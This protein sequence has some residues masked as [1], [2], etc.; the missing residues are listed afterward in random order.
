M[1]KAALISPY[2]DTLGGGEKYFLDI[3]LALEKLGIKTTLFW[4]NNI[5]EKIVEQYGV[6]YRIIELSTK[7]D[8]MSP[9][10]KLLFTRQFDYLFFITDGSYFFSLAKK[11]FVLLQVPQNNLLPKTF[12]QKA[13]TFNFQ[14]FV[15]SSF[16]KRYFAKHNI[17]KSPAVIHPL[18][19]STDTVAINK[20]KIILS[21]GRFFE[22]LHSKQQEVLIKAFNSAVKNHAEFKDY[23]LI[24]A[25]SYKEEDSKYLDYLQKLAS[26]NPA[27]EFKLNISKQEMNS[28]YSK[29]VIYGHA[30]GYKVNEKTNPE[31]VEHFG[32][33]ICEA[34]LERAVPVVYKAGGPKEIIQENKTGF[35]FLTGTD[36]I[37]I[38]K[39][40]INNSGLRLEIGN[41]AKATITAKFSQS[42]FLQKI[43][44]LIT[45]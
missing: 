29:A 19:D 1:K 31:R 32:I 45:V 14:P 2:L 34:M 33:S 36:L 44:N 9:F 28:L 15:F 38:T 26:K 35:F 7:W 39:K 42:V 5:K 30:A 27:I 37:K 41:N 17:W 12:W 40:L 24:L 13:K 16:V 22:H 4:K 3:A 10:Q 20:E 18:V 25:G 8:N 11:N 43:N 23:K 6:N 21:V